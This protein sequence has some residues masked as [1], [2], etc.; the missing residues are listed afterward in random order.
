MA[1]VY[2][3]LGMLPERLIPYDTPDGDGCSRFESARRMARMVGRDCVED[4]G[5]DEW[6]AL[7]ANIRGPA[8]RPH[9]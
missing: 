3:L 9:R 2:N 7:G 4:E 5:L 6:V 1:D 8:E